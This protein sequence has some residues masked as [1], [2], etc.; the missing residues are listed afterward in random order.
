MPYKNILRDKTRS[1]R[2]VTWGNVEK[3]CYQ[4]EAKFS[5]NTDFE[6]ATIVLTGDKRQVRVRFP[7]SHFYQIID[8]N[9]ASVIWD[10]PV[11]SSKGAE[12]PLYRIENSFLI[13]QIVHNAG[14]VLYKQELE[15]YRILTNNLLIDIILYEGQSG[16]I[17]IEEVVKNGVG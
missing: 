12:Y 17:Q 4:A 9:L 2:R 14:G 16:D 10:I 6:L 15:H 3:D 5:E 1:E 13:E 8:R 11:N 7:F